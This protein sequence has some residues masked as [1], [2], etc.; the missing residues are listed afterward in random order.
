[1]ANINETLDRLDG[2]H[3]KL[4]QG[5]WA[6]TDG[7][8]DSVS[9]MSGKTTI[10][11]TVCDIR[12]WGHLQKLGEK[13]AVAVQ[14]A[15]ESYI[16][17]LHNA[18]P[19]IRDEIRRLQNQIA[20][21]GKMVARLNQERRWIPVGERLPEN[22]K[23]VLV[24]ATRKLQDGRVFQVRSMAMYEDGS[25]PTG[26]SGYM[27]EDCDFQYNDNSDDYLVPEGWWEQ[28]EYSETFCAVDDEVTHWMPLPGG[29]EE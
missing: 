4:P 10:L 21:L 8:G 27:W 26:K 6:G 9:C 15:T 5:R 16:A 19:A 22:E 23:R 14:E 29:M 18:F 17:E 25:M 1:M 3:A 28:P 7:Y 12:G 2:L 11:Y 20:D 24:C 13:E